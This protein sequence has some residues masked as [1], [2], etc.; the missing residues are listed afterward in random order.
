M[1][2]LLKNLLFTVFVPGTVAGLA[3]WLISRD[4]PVTWGV[5][6]AVALLLFASGAAIYFW[7]VWDF[8]S[9]G[10]GTPAPIDAPKSLVVRGLYRYSRN[11]M[12]V[13][14]LTTLLGWVV[15]FASLE[16]LVYSACV[17]TCFQLFV[18]C[19]EEPHLSRTFG[20]S[21]DEYRSR[22]S[23]WIPVIRRRSSA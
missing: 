17:G 3:P 12:Y 5:G 10:R 1:I 6:A 9:F 13:G 15:L 19:Y 23:R 4:E 21:Y 7:C 11:P 2:L 8:A 18:V 14:V 16:L 20:K 22:V